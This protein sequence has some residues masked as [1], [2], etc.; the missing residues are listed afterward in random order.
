M[1]PNICDWLHLFKSQISMPLIK[2][3]KPFNTFH[4]EVTSIC[5]LWFDYEPFVP[6]L[7]G[8]GYKYFKIINVVIKLVF[9]L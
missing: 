7:A 6:N 8:R 2:P 5:Y 9:L 3:A 4:I 1:S